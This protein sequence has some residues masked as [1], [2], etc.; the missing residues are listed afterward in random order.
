MLDDALIRP[1]RCLIHP[2]LNN[3]HGSDRER[4]CDAGDVVDRHVAFCA[5]DRTAIGPVDSDFV[6]ERLLAQAARPAQRAHVFGQDVPQGASG[7]S[8]P[9]H[10]RAN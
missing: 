3:S 2:A 4:L 6:R 8:F 5:F 1:T 9:G 7:C 10:D